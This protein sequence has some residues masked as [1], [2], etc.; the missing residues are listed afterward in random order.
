MCV[1]AASQRQ[2][3]IRAF[4]SAR[5]G[6]GRDKSLA[7]SGGIDLDGDG[8]VSKEEMGP[9]TEATLQ[10]WIDDA[11]DDMRAWTV[12]CAGP[13]S[14]MASAST[15]STRLRAGNTHCAWC[16]DDLTP[17]VAALEVDSKP[18]FGPVKRADGVFQLYVEL[19][20]HH[21]LEIDSLTFHGTV[22]TP[23]ARAWADA[24]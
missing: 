13:A 10:E 11:D 16:V 19:P 20:Y 5:M 12:F 2:C 9:I 6:C 18:F 8:V 15:P 24:V 7:L 1:H 23:S 21:Y 3:S 4:A 14:S 22:G 17:V